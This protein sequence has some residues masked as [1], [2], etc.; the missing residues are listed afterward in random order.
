VTEIFFGTE[1]KPRARFVELADCG[2][3]FE[4]EMMD[5][6]MDQAQTMPDGKSVDVQVILKR[7]P[8][9][10]I[11]IRSSLRYGNV[12]KKILRD[13]EEIK[14]KLSHDKRR[15]DQKVERLKSKVEKIDETDRF[16]ND[17][18]KIKRMLDRENLTDEQ[19]NLIDNQIRFLAFL[20]TLK[21][22]IGSFKADKR[23][24][25]TKKDLENKIGQLRDRVMGSQVQ[26]SYQEREELKE[27]MFRTKLLIDL[28]M[29]KMQLDIRGIQLG[30][31]DTVVVDYIGEVLDSEKKIDKKRRERYRTRIE[32]IRLQQKGVHQG[33]AR[34]E[35][36][37][38]VKGRGMTQGHWFKCPNGHIFCITE[39]GETIRET[40]CRKCLRK[41][42]D[43]RNN[44]SRITTPRVWRKK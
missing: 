25:E 18:D 6:W 43:D 10:K 36:D 39:C 8:K 42:V 33:A 1:D 38:I 34:E 31:T 35:K 15:C 30:D 44:W 4:V 12:V 28:R 7:C 11:P 41:T 24:R 5:Q 29:L 40:K 32:R 2:H 13:F 26:F 9:C 17:Q 14:Q 22:N 16:P 23:S 21:A 37:L 20:Q 3:V 19:I 27:E